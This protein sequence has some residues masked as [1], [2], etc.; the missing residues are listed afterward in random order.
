MTDEQVAERLNEL[1]NFRDA[2]SL[3]NKEL[4][5]HDKNRFPTRERVT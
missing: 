4:L 2:V 5:K 1:Q 3:A